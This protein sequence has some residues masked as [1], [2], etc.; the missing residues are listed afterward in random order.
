MSRIIRF[1]SSSRNLAGQKGNYDVIKAQNLGLLRNDVINRHKIIVG[2]TLDHSKM[3]FW[4]WSQCK[5]QI[6]AICNRCLETITFFRSSQKLWR[7]KVWRSY[8]TNYKVLCVKRSLHQTG[9]IQGWTTEQEP[10]RRSKS[11]VRMV[12][13]AQ[14]KWANKEKGSKLVF[15]L[16]IGLQSRLN[17]HYKK[18]CKYELWSVLRLWLVL[19]NSS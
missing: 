1:L 3:I 16:Y 13:S 11:W 19:Q 9:I 17:C 6:W 5:N 12:Y 8:F 2:Q 15:F 14:S 7:K 10:S 4:R 18:V